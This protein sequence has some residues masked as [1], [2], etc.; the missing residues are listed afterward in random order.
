MKMPNESNK[1]IIIIENIKKDLPL[2]NKTKNK[3]M[4]NYN[5]HGI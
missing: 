3:E 2:P 1:D 4:K 5:N